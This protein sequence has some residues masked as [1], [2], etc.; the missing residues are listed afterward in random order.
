MRESLLEK[1]RCP[2][3]LGT[4]RM[5]SVGEEDAGQIM[6]GQLTC[7]SCERTYPIKDGV[8]D[9]VPCASSNEVRADLSRVRAA[10]VERFGFEW[11]YFRDWGWLPGYP[12][13][14]GASEKFYGG[15]VMHT[16]GAF[17]SKSL[18]REGELK[19]GHLVLDAGCGNGRFTNEAAKT[20]AEVIGIDLGARVYR[21]FEHTRHL[22]N[23][24]IV[25]GDLLCLPFQEGLFDRVFSIGVLQ[26]TGDASAAFDSLVR[27][28]KPGWFIV[29]HVYGKGRGIYEILDRSIRM[30]T[31]RLPISGQLRFARGM[32]TL[33]RWL[34]AGGDRRTRFY[35]RLYNYVNL[36]PTE[37]HMYDWWSA[38]VATHQTPREVMS[39]FDRNRLKIVRTNFSLADAAA[40]EKRRCNH[41]SI[42]VM[43]QSQVA[44]EIE[45]SDSTKEK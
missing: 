43:G 5:S 12:D 1:L 21:S 37:H 17:R 26:H 4:L 19:S 36:L 44:N 32:A 35:W 20:G 39:W 23:V 42:T 29:V 38:P 34:R 24:H 13:V 25:L 11:D 22:T 40:E 9:M 41:E 33:A 8:P 30:V 45:G 31:V 27:K 2:V 18:F 3:D 10:T 6:A 14:P 7:L 16:Q 15:L 28:L